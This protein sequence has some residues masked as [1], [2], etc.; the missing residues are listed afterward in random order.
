MFVSKYFRTDRACA[1]IFNNKNYLTVTSDTC[2]SRTFMPSVQVSVRGEDRPSYCNAGR[3]YFTCALEQSATFV[4]FWRDASSSRPCSS[5]ALALFSDV[6][7]NG[8]LAIFSAAVFSLA[9]RE[10]LLELKLK[11]LEA[12]VQRGQEEAVEKAAYNF[13]C[14]NN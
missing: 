2:T 13:H 11:Q 14:S 12:V 3:H 7:F 8:F 9:F 4:S 1:K 6:D 10:P 5:T